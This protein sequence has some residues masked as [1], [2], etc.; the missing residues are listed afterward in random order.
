M[1]YV[2]LAI[3]LAITGT[4]GAGCSIIVDGA[5]EDRDGS[6][7]VMDCAGAT[8]GADC[9]GGRICVAETCTLSQCGD[10]VVD[11]AT[12]EDCDDGNET[13]LDGCENDC[14]FT[15]SAAADCDDD[16]ECNG[17]EVCGADHVCAA[18]TPLASGDACTQPE[19]DPGVCRDSACV[20]AGCGN[21]LMDGGEECDDGNMVDGDGC[22]GDCTF[23]CSVDTD[24]DD[25]SVCT[26]TE[27]CDVATHACVAGEMLAC[28]DGSPCTSDECDAVM[29]CVHP[30]IDEDM[31]GYASTDLG[32]CGDDCNDARED[33]NPGEVELCGDT[34]DSDCDGETNPGSTPFWYL[35]CDGDRY[36]ALGA[37]SQQQCDEPPASGCGGGWTSRV[38]VS[39]DRT[40]YD[41][42]DANANVRP[43]QTS[44]FSTEISATTPSSIDFDYDCNLM[45]ERRYTT[46]PAFFLMCGR[47][48]IGSAGWTGGV[49]PVCGATGT[50]SQCVDR[51]GTCNRVSTTRT[52]TCR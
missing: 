24:C 47:G 52:Q 35:D 36:A 37:V 8:D 20:P 28:N 41:C 3:A 49:V 34:L 15:C 7:V 33:V 19:G 50:Y 10:R 30:L 12:G 16:L 4:L 21:G 31:D 22:D 38:P 51:L 6:V 46:A 5:I 27:T 13:A 14:E 11:P 40:T 32:A 29:G 2:R 1:T 48:C 25:A 26:G 18:G 42:N 17:A 45:E 9:G 44:Y 39:G 43:N 23:S